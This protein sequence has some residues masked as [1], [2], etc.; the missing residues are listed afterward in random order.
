[1]VAIRLFVSPRR[2]TNFPR[3]RTWLCSE[4]KK[5]PPTDRTGG[6]N[7]LTVSAVNFKVVRGVLKF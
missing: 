1:M 3:K 5:P 6:T 7:R 4:E 2:E